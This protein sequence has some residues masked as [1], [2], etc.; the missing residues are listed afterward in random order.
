M[1]VVSM[2]S[3]SRSPICSFVYG[4]RFFLGRSAVGR[5]KTCLGLRNGNGSGPSETRKAKHFRSYRCDIQD[6][7]LLL[8]AFTNIT[9]GSHTNNN[10]RNRNVLIVDLHLHLNMSDRRILAY[11][12]IHSEC[13]KHS[14]WVDKLK[15][16][17]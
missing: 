10:P 3:C 9:N 5:A 4:F 16:I 15:I 17:H 2:Y 1:Y 11:K 6:R 12:S 8:E 7:L 14:A 13:C